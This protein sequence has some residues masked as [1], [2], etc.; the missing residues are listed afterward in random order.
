MI[1]HGGEEEP[2]TFR[3]LDAGGEVLETRSLNLNEVGG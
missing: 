2:Q 1:V 3:F